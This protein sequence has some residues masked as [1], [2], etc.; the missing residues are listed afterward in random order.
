MPFLI[1]F[2]ELISY[3][4]TCVDRNLIVTFSKWHL[5]FYFLIA[6]LEILFQALHNPCLSFNYHVPPFLHPSDKNCPI[7]HTLCFL[8]F[9]HYLFLQGL[10]LSHTYYIYSGGNITT[11]F[12]SLVTRLISYILINILKKNPS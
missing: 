1:N 12:I 2:C 4:Y 8:S 9:H 5:T 10:I 7:T 3:Q 11:I 6:S